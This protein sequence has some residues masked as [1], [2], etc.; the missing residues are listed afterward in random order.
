MSQKNAGKN[1]AIDLLRGLSIVY[2]VGFWHLFDITNQF[3]GYK[4]A[5]THNLTVVVLSVFVFLS[6]YLLAGADGRKGFPP[7]GRF[8]KTRFLK[9]YPP[10]A[11]VAIIFFVFGLIDRITLL[12]TLT[13]LSVFWG[14]PAPTIW[15]IGMIA[16]F[17]VFTPVLVWASEQSVWVFFCWALSIY[18]GCV[19]FSYLFEPADERLLLYFPSFVMGIGVSRFHPILPKSLHYVAA[20]VVACCVA[21]VYYFP[22]VEPQYLPQFVPLA[23][24]GALVAFYGTKDIVFSKNL[25]WLANSLAGPSYM[26][27]LVHRPVYAF[28]RRIYWPE[29][30]LQIPYLIFVCFPVA[31]VSA[32]YAH[33][34]YETLFKR[35]MRA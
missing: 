23:I 15:F 25:A 32:V 22:D 8:F 2:I 27:F 34:L 28:M 14:P 12:K 35:M 20:S 31:F 30:F 19:A 29:G 5:V 26:L 10:F 16:V 7:L 18:L 33:R 4:N 1:V 13:L 21:L 6:G 17:Y 9:I 24:S 3:P 11:L